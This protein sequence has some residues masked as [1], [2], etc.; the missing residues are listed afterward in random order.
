M[1]RNY[2]AKRD[3]KN[4]GF[5]MQQHVSTGPVV[6]VNDK[7][8]LS[9]FNKKYSGHGFN[10]RGYFE[11]Y[12]I[13]KDHLDEIRLWLT[14]VDKTNTEDLVLHLRLG[15]RLF[16]RN[17]YD[18]GMKVEPECFLRAIEKFD[19]HRLHIVTDM[20]VWDKITVEQAMK[21][22]FHIRTP[23]EPDVMKMGVNHMN[24]LVESFK[25][26]SP[27][28]RLNQKISDDFNFIRSFDKILFQ[29]GTLAWWAAA[30]SHASKVGVYGP[31]RPTKGPKNKNLGKADFPGWFGWSC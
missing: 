13:Y 7:R 28:V 30:V 24:S 9:F 22:R 4:I 25:P 11:D 1:P 14:P 26:L 17:S 6:E 10:V 23:S 12:L 8:P 19:F 3:L 29:H 15:D 27:I 5:V 18:P 20:K 2:Y 21:M 16:Y 31:W